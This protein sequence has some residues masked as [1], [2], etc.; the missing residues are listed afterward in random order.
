MIKMTNSWQDSKYDFDKIKTKILN[1]VSKRNQKTIQIYKKH[2][3]AF[4]KK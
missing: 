2:V 4:N 3:S 1:F